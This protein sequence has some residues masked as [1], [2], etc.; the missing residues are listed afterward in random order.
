MPPANFLNLVFLG[1]FRFLYAEWSWTLLYLSQPHENSYP[2]SWH[3]EVYVYEISWQSEVYF[4][5][6]IQ[7][8]TPTMQPT[9][10]D[11]IKYIWYHC[12][13]IVG[14][15]G[16]VSHRCENE[17]TKPMPQ[18]ALSGASR[19]CLGPKSAG[20]SAQW[21]QGVRP[22]IHWAIQLTDEPILNF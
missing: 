7:K 5:V 19:R 10:S 15:S 16:G 18:P 1:F 22:P 2:H 13:G 6:L 11:N 14:P 3:C 12:W 20:S 21:V 17:P 9:P 4:L 8:K